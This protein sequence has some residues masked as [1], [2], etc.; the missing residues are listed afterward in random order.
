MDLSYTIPALLIGLGGSL[1]CIGM[2]GPLMFSA[3][4]QPGSNT[5][6]ASK[7]LLYQSGRILTYALWGA[8]LG[9][10][11]FSLHWFDWQQNMSLALGV[12]ILAVLF[13]LKFFPTVES[14]IAS[15]RFYRMITR[16]LSPFIMARNNHASFFSGVLNGTLPCG[17]V[18][19]A[20][21]GATVMQDPF[22]GSIFMVA[23][24]LGT[25]PMLLAILFAGK[26]LQPSIRKYISVA[27]PYILASMALLLIIR[28]LN[29]GYVFSP[30]LSPEKPGI[31]HCAT[32]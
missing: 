11:G 17:L 32:E 10:I 22:K 28:G 5:F 23:F 27:Y 18:Y 6:P 21:A 29:L 20:I 8:L 19:M 3:I 26:S 2:C 24:G 7:W 25:L 9:S 12:S 31:V 15:N 13:V 4:L 16:K 1:H 30:V 14:T